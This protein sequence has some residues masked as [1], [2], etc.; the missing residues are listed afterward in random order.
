M[1]GKSNRRDILR[2][3]ALL[4]IS[5]PVAASLA[6]MAGMSSA[7]AST[8]GTLSVTYYD[9]IVNLHPALNTVNEDFN[10]TFPLD[11]QV[12]PTQG[13]GIER[14]VQEARD[15]SSTWDTY[16]GVTPFL[17]MIALA[18][19]GAIEPWDPYLPEGFLD[20]IPASIRAEGTY[21]DSF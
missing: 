15:G 13:F 21:N 5:A 11:A 3:A 9:W 17:E 6:S 2:R 18:E 1:S 10:A 20:N 14:F 12:A 19:S 7:L 16:I 4:G 8:E